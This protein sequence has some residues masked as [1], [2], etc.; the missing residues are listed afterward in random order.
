M[1]F[2]FCFLGQRSTTTGD[3]HVS[4]P[5]WDLRHERERERE[6]ERE[7]EGIKKSKKNFFT[8]AIVHGISTVDD[9]YVRMFL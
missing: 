9:P 6:R 3:V 1:F 7:N 2:N 8:R 4:D 5:H